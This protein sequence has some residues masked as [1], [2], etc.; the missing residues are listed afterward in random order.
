MYGCAV[1]STEGSVKGRSLIEPFFPTFQSTGAVVYCRERPP[2]TS[3]PHGYALVTSGQWKAR[4][5]HYVV[6]LLTLLALQ[7]DG[8]KYGFDAALGPPLADHIHDRSPIASM[9]AALFP[10]L[11]CGVCTPTLLSVPQLST[12]RAAGTCELILHDTGAGW[13]V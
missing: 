9:L 1:R 5:Q 13:G 8:F 3:R 4:Q 10:V 7:C 6:V 12:I 2:S 11:D